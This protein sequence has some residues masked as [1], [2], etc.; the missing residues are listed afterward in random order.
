MHA[1]RNEI[2]QRIIHKAML[3][4]PAPLCKQRCRDPDAQVGAKGVGAGPCMPGMRRTFIDHFDK[5]GLQPIPQH[6]FDAP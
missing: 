1:L 6:I 3:R 5:S 4:D 2:P